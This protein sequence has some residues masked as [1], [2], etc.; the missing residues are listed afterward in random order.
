MYAEVFLTD[1]IKN[2]IINL[3]MHDRKNNSSSR[4]RETLGDFE[5]KSVT[6]GPHQISLVSMEG[7]LSAFSDDSALYPLDRMRQIGEIID[8]ADLTTLEYFPPEIE[9]TVGVVPLLG[10]YAMKMSDT[11]EYTIAHYADIA[12][13]AHEKDKHV[14]VADIANRF[15]YAYYALNPLNLIMEMAANNHD[16]APSARERYFATMTDARR[17]LTAEA[18][19]READRNPQGAHL[20][21]I[22]APAHVQRIE[23]YIT[24]PPGPLDKLRLALYASALSNMDSQLRIYEPTDESWRLLARRKKI[25]Q[26]MGAQAISGIRNLLR[27]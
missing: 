1:T 9:R 5:V 24:Q 10:A 11:P 15:S 7:M 27:K 26:Q 20:A 13:L 21:Y 14:G 8:Q 6:F 16:I 12:N 3:F 18:L 17:M 2:V 19:K 25:G 23:K 4:A 22:G